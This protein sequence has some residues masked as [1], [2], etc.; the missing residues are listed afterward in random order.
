MSS[1][2]NVSEFHMI[3]LYL[4]VALLVASSTA[5][6]ECWVISDL[7]G[8]SAREA[9]SY[10]ISTD[11]FSGKTFEI[12]INDKDASVAP[13]NISCMATSPLSALCVEQRQSKST[14]ETWVISPSTGKAFHTKSISGYGSFDGANLFVGKV[15][16]KCN[17]R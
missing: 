14:V 9:E 16:G 1:N 3:R 11:G 15:S 13:S 7:R 2:F 17:A 5:A 12:N 6:A 4:Y 8:Y 10:R